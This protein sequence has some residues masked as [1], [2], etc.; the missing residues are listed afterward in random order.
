MAGVGSA[1]SRTIALPHGRTLTVRPS[2][3]S[4][5]PGLT[6]LYE[7]LSL[8]DRYHRFFSGSMPKNFVEKWT[9][10]AERGGVGLVAVV[11]NGA[12]QIVAEAGF[13]LLPDGDAELAITVAHEWRGW[14]GAYLL[15]ALV[16]EAAERGIPNLQAEILVDNGPMFALVRSRGYAILDHGDWSSVRVTIGTSASAPDWPA[17][18]DR[19]RVLVETPRGRWPSTNA[20]VA[21]GLRVIGCPG[22]TRGPDG[23]PALAGRPCP[24]AQHADVIVF[25]F[26]PS[27]PQAQAILSAHPRLHDAVP[28]VV[29]PPASGDQLEIPAE[30]TTVAAC[31]PAAEVI[32]LVSE[33][34]ARRPHDEADPPPAP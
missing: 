16:Q 7:H 13:D 21:G 28:L 2:E 32:A 22:P 5:A 12:E 24:L 29:A 6:G 3:P 30:A 4:D 15:D 27:D 31:T 1:H 25:A 33:L 26:G 17:G 20:A 19:P 10:V 9:R 8:D 11:A 34:A 18:D 23:C 14:L